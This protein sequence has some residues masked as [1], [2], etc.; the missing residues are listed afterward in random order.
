MDSAKIFGQLG[1][2]VA[3]S[4]IRVHNYM[5]GDNFAHADGGHCCTFGDISDG[6]LQVDT[7][8]GFLAHIDGGHCSCVYTYSGSESSL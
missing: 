5:V 7:I 1:V 8:G 3:G 6:S 2:G 4:G